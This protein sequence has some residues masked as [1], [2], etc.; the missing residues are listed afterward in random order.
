MLKYVADAFVK[1]GAHDVAFLWCLYADDV[2]LAWHKTLREDCECL[3]A[4]YEFTQPSEPGMLSMIV[5]MT[6]GGKSATHDQGP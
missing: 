1:H 5:A 4:R 6:V 3:G 2:P